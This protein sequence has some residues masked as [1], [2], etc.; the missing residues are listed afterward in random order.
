MLSS[1]WEQLSGFTL[2]PFAC[3]IR[4]WVKDLRS[5]AA[6]KALELSTMILFALQW[7]VYWG[8]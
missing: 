4:A 2:S 8:K 3:H 7:H 1:R 6:L 5:G